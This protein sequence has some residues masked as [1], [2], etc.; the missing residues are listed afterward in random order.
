[1]NPIFIFLQKVSYSYP[2]VLSAKENL[3]Y[4]DI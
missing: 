4:Y 3:G 2:L 1:M